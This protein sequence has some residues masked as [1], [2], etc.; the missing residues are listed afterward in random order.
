MREGSAPSTSLL[1][2]AAY[3]E[4]FEP[5]LQQSDLL[6]VAFSSEMSAT[7]QNVYAAQE[8]LKEKYPERKFMVVDTLTISYP[9]SLLVLGAHQLYEQ[10]APMDEVAQWL[11][12]NR[13]RANAWFTVDDL[14]YLKRGGRVSPTSAFVGS[15]LDIKPILALSRA[16]KIEAAGKVQGRKKAMRY[17]ADKTAELI[18]NAE[19]QEVYVLHAD[20][21]AAANE[22]AAMI[23]SKVP[24]VKSVA[25]RMIGPVIGSHCGPGTLCVAFMGKER[26]L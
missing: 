6:F 16:G 22:L 1:P 20:A 5:I 13:L 18:E 9:M 8:E 17:L 11:M 3:L 21:E 25:L 23:K 12:D 4:Y 2:T 24:Q 19:N 14:V 10:G 7:I 15:M 26:A